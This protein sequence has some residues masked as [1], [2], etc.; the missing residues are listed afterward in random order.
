MIDNRTPEQKKRDFLGFD[1]KEKFPPAT[2]PKEK[3]E[4]RYKSN[5]KT[6]EE[7]RAEL[8]LKKLDIEIAKL[9][10]PS[11]SIDYFQKM[12]E[13][14][15]QFNN[16]LMEMQKESFDVKLELMKLQMG[17]ESGD[18]TLQYLEIFK[19]LMPLMKQQPQQ[20]NS[21]IVTESATKDI[22]ENHKQL[23]ERGKKQMD[24][25]DGKAV[26]ELR[27]KIKSGELSEDDAYKDFKESTPVKISSKISKEYFHEIFEKVKNEKD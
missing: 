14:Q 3:S 12:L 13:L 11:T 18:N 23:S 25:T 27:K 17:G 24:F 10:Q 9:E 26:E 5:E 21:D 8:E 1:V 4:Y 6:I 2:P 22:K 19:E 7:K 15:T 16:K 20:I